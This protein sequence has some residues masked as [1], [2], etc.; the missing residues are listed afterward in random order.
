MTRHDAA[1]TRFSQWWTRNVRSGHASLELLFRHGRAAGNSRV[2]RIRSIVIWSLGPTGLALIFGGVAGWQWGLLPL[3]LYGL[4]AAKTFRGELG[5]GRSVEHAALYGVA[6]TIG[7][8]P[9]LQG[10]LRYLRNRIT[11]KE[12]NDLIEYKGAGE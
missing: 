6:C 5:R 7:K 4:V 2:G 3:A 1:L 12:R 11:R 10:C 8:F 9:E